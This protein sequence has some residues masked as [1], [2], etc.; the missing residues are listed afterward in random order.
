MSAVVPLMSADP[1]KRDID[2]LALAR[3]RN[4]GDRERLLLALTTL[5]RASPGAAAAQS[6]ILSEIF[7]TLVRQAERDIRRTL[8]KQLADADWAP[9]ALINMLALDEIEIARPIIAS[10][11]LL[12]EDQLLKILIEATLEHQIEVARRPALSGRL[13]DHIIDRGDPAVMTALASNASAEVTEASLARLVEHSRRIA[14]LRAPLV[15]H[16]RLSSQLAGQLYEWV[17]AALRQSIGERF[18]VDPAKLEAAVHAATQAVVHPAPEPP[19]LTP[20]QRDE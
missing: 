8:A 3:S 16:P 2:L 11:P 15:R 13:V 1:A 14:A 9:V 20:A 4:P 7:V 10:N 12:A 18:N 19:A 5:C 17:G 6:P